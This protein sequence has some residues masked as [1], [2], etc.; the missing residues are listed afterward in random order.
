MNRTPSGAD[1]PYPHP[2]YA[3]YVVVVLL[4]ALWPW[5]VWLIVGA[6]YARSLKGWNASRLL[7]AD[8]RQ[9][10]I[11]GPQGIEEI[12]IAC[13]DADALQKLRRIA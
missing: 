10:A 7:A 1:A 11:S 12:L 8:T 9:A 2:L 4:L 3:W 5:N 13:D 6:A